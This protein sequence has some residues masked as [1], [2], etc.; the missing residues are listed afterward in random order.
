MQREVV[1]HHVHLMSPRLMKLFTDVGI[2]F[3][4]PFDDY[5]VLDSLVKRDGTSHVHLASMAYLYGHPEFG[6]VEDEYAAVR[7]ENNFIIAARDSA[8]RQY[9]V[10]SYCGVNPLRDYA[11]QEVERCVR[12]LRADGIKLHFNAN[13]VYLTEPEHLQKVKAIFALFAR[14]RLPVL[15]HFDNSHPKF[16][17][18][19]VDLLVNDVLAGT[20]SLH[21]QIAHFGTSGGFS[22]KTAVVINRF[23]ALFEAGE[24]LRRHSVVFDLSGVALDKDSDGVPQLDDARFAEL[25][26]LIRRL[27]TQRI[28]F[29]TD[30]PLYSAPEYL[31]ILRMRAG[32]SDAEVDDILRKK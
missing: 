15:L 28:V 19:D 10:T 17:A 20:D 32:L 25:A 29:G 14:H 27:G 4:R 3:S 2:P 26:A 9:A 30:Y 22:E 24:V 31:T 8:P 12:D 7:A 23:I 21:L 6:R 11:Q 1:D 5:S 16:G 18:D 13:Q